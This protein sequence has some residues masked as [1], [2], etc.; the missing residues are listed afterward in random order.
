MQTYC[1]WLRKFSGA[2][3]K[4]DVTQQILVTKT[5]LF[6]TFTGKTKKLISV[7]RISSDKL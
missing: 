5:L 3:A 4:E 1:L 7:N 6:W 2:P